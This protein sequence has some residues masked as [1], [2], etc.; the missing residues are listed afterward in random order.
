[1]VFFLIKKIKKTNLIN[2]VVNR[3]IGMAATIKISKIL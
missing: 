2:F 3:F 1:M